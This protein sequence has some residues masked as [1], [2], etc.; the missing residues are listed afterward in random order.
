[1]PFSSL[2]SGHFC[3]FRPKVCFFVSR[4]KRFEILPFS[5]GSLTPSIFFVKSRVFP[6]GVNK[7]DENGK[8]SNLLDLDTKKQ[9][10]GRKSQKWPDL[11]ENDIL[12]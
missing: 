4:S 10:F 11:D 5:S 3:G 2:R 8:I 7:P 6:D 12:L 9:T 1:M